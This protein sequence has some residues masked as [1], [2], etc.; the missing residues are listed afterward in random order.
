MACVFS[1]IIMLRNLSYQNY[2][3]SLKSKIKIQSYCFIN[4]CVHS[5]MFKYHWTT[6]LSSTLIKFHFI[7]PSAPNYSQLQ[8]DFENLMFSIEMLNNFMWIFEFIRWWINT[9]WPTFYVSID[10][11]FFRHSKTVTLI[12]QNLQSNSNFNSKSTS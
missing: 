9:M 1:Q 7:P 4:L 2:S 6:V 10:R 5:Y 3:E 8:F 11:H 12:P